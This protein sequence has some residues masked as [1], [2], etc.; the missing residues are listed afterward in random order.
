[1]P[2]TV[3]TGTIFVVL[4]GSILLRLQVHTYVLQLLAWLGRIHAWG[5]LVFILIEIGVVIFILPGIL[6]TLG[7]GF[8]FGPFWGTL[9]VITGQILGG[10]MAFVFAR[11]LFRK[12]I[13]KFFKKHPLLLQLDQRLAQEN[14]KL[15]LLTR[16]IPLFPCKLANYCF[17]VMRFSL[18]DYLIGTAL[19]SFPITLTLV[20]AG[21]LAGDLANIRSVP[22]HRG[23]TSWIIAGVLLVALGGGV[24]FMARTARKRLKIDNNDNI[25]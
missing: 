17:G 7:A 21:S 10:A 15:I 20:Y 19:G 16:L 6:F 3:L 24:L 11:T 1:M 8:L 25:H 23:I 2:W 13:L 14:W 4:G 5:P 18:R 12:Q 22:D 9:Y